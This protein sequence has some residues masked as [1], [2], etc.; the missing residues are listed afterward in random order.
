MMIRNNMLC[1]LAVLTIILAG[2][3]ENPSDLRGSVIGFVRVD[4]EF[5]REMSDHSG[6]LVSAGNISAVTDSNGRYELKAVPAG[7]YHLNFQKDGAGNYARYNFLFAGGSTPALASEVRMIQLPT[8]TASGISASYQ[9][10]TILISGTLSATDSYWIAYLIG[11]TP[12]VGLD[13][14]KRSSSVSFCCG[15]VNEF[16]HGIYIDLTGYPAA[17]VVGYAVSI[18]TQQYN[19]GYYDAEKKTFV[20]GGYK[21]IFGPIKVK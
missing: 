21:K 8:L 15:T 3:E 1:V 10:G 18:G 2:C 6:V 5:G 14:Y 9:P 13:N 20:F 12:D 4:N 7:N 16:N 19:Y 17:Y 11:D